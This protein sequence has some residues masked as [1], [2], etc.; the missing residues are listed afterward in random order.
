[1]PTPAISIDF[2]G[3]GADIADT[4]MSMATFDS[5]WTYIVEA[6]TGN[7]GFATVTVTGLDLAGNTITPISGTTTLKVDNTAPI[8]IPTSP[9]EGDF[10]RTTAVA[11]DLGETIASGQVIWTWEAGVTDGASPHV[12]A[13][14]GSELTAGTH[15]GLLTNVASLVQAAAYTIG[16]I[17]VD[18]V[19]NADTME[20]ETITYDTLAPGIQSVVVYDGPA[21]DLDSTCSTDTLTVHYSGFSELTSGI[22]LY[23]YSLG[24]TP[25]GTNVIDWTGNNTDTLAT[26]RGLR[27]AYKA[28]YYFS[29]RAT[30]GAGN[31]SDS[32]S[33]DGIRIVDKPRLMVS[34]VPNSVFSNYL[35]IFVTDTLA[36][37][38][39]IRI[40]ADS[41]RVTSTLIDTFSYSYVG[42]HELEE[43]GPHSLS[44]TG[45]SGMGDTTCTY[46]LSMALAK[47]DQAW[48]AISADQRFTTMGL[49]GSVSMDRYLLVVDSTLMGLSAIHGGAYRLGDGQFPFNEPVR[50]SMQPAVA[51]GRGGELQAIYIFR[52]DGCWEELPTVDDGEQVS[53]WVRRAG[54]FR[55]GPRTIVVPQ[56]TSLHQNYPNPFNPTTCISFDLGFQDGPR[57]QVKVVIHNLLGQQVRTLYDGEAST[58]RYQLVWDGV[59]DQGAAVASGIYFVRLSTGSGYQKT[60]KM[61]LIR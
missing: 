59:D 34:A 11:Y 8:I 15:S 38:D 2:A 3:T 21:A 39:S 36:M 23:E 43:T 44:V 60:K 27:L 46:S 42:T 40:L 55:L 32:V 1:Q 4:A 13:L 24:T 25:G 16:F 61:L 10:V 51:P 47:K 57:Q 56:A 19:G 54:T 48:I 45:F 22:V 35:Q 6:P 49:P 58:G 18:R 41:V 17:A 5:I 53:T 29:V 31:V 30:D 37:A 28:Y 52:M 50:V 14:T 9:E 33:S 12:Q 26:V 20:V 7:D